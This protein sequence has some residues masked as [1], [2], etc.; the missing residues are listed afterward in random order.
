MWE[1][2]SSAGMLAKFPLGPWGINLAKLMRVMF[3]RSMLMD[4]LSAKTQHM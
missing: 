2:A 1:Q 3:L 4:A